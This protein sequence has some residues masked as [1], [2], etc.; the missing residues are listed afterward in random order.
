MRILPPRWAV[1]EMVVYWGRYPHRAEITQGTVNGTIVKA[2]E[3]LK[4]LGYVEAGD[5][6]VTT[7]GDP[8]MSVQLEDKVSSTNVAYVSSGTLNRTC[9]QI[10]IAKG[11]EGI[12][13]RALRPSSYA[14]SSICV[15]SRSLLRC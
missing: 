10:C 4:E 3:T 6:T 11:P 5:L 12:A 8:R 2:I 1:L 15:Q 14:A 9:K 7:A 13:F